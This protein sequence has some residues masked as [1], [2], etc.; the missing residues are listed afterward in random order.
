MSGKVLTIG[1]FESFHKGHQF[2]LKHTARLAQ[3]RGLTSVVVTFEPHPRQVLDTEPYTPLFTLKEREA[4]LK[5]FNIDYFSPYAFNADFINQTPADFCTQLSNDFDIREL[6]LGECF[7][8][9]KNR[10]G[11]IDTIKQ[12][13]KDHGIHLHVLN[14]IKQES[15]KI[16]TSAI[17]ERI[18]AGKLSEAEA[19]LG[20]SF[21]ADGTVSH[22][23]QVG[24]K[25]GFPTVNILPSSEK[26]LPTDGVYATR[27][28]V[29]DQAYQGVTNV[30]IRPSF[31]DGTHRTIETFLLDYHD[32]AL[33]G[34]AIRI[35]F[36]HFIR[37]EIPFKDP[38]ALRAQIAGDVE[39]ARVR[40]VDVEMVRV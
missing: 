9:G 31:D 30:G 12:W 14:H 29:G 5:D 1:K 27:V 3:E 28:H 18:A 21:F 23:K 24:K 2:L 32:D 25:L 4:M 40:H 36:L 20:F 6:V 35:Y 33:Y 17:R 11:S 38:D 13:S 37:P 15:A 19:L 22:G 26:F 39:L 10:G 16:S 8:F 7:Q 34:K